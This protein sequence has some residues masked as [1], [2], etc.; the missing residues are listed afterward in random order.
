[1]RWQLIVAP[2]LLV[3]GMVGPALADKGG[4]G[5]D[6]G[7]EGREAE[8]DEG[9]KGHGGH[10][11]DD[12]RDERDEREADGKGH[13]AKVKGKT[14]AGRPVLAIDQAFLQKGNVLTFAYTVRNLGDGAA[15]DVRLHT[16]LPGEGP[17]V[18]ADPACK[19][20]AGELSC[21]I[22]LVPAHG[23]HAVTAIDKDAGDLAPFTTVVQVWSSA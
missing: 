23:K 19:V 20:A 8:G 21:T 13:G 22:A 3:A 15:R 4:G 14:P 2:L 12:E 17:W 6:E 10:D 18:V 5:H 11:E 1:M 7:G 9:N 16:D